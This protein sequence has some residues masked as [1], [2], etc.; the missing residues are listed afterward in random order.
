VNVIVKIADRE[1]IPVRAI[2][3]LTNWRFMEPFDIAH[4]LGGT[5]G[6]NVS[7]FGELKSY[8]VESDAVQS[9]NEDRWVQFSLV[10]LRALSRR[11][12]ATQPYDDEGTIEWM[13]RSLSILPP[14][15]FVWRSEYEALHRENWRSQYQFL[16]FAL[17][18]WDY[19]GE[20]N[21]ATDAQ[22]EHQLDR[23]LTRESLVSD[24]PLRRD[25][26]E[27]LAVLKRWREPD[28][29][30]F[31]LPDLAA[32][33]MEGF[34]SQGA[35]L[36][37]TGVGQLHDS[38]AGLF[39]LIAER[40]TLMKGMI[41]QAAS[42]E[43]Q[44]AQVAAAQVEQQLE[45]RKTMLRRREETLE[46]ASAT[47][48]EKNVT[49][50]EIAVSNATVER[51]AAMQRMQAM[52]GDFPERVDTDA[53]VMNGSS[54]SNGRVLGA[55]TTPQAAPVTGDT[56]A[57]VPT[58]EAAAA[59][60]DAP[61]AD[62]PASDPP[63]WKMRIQTEAAAHMKRLRASGA[64]PTVHSTVDHMAKWCRENDV[65]TDGSI[66]PSANYLRTHVLGGKHWTPPR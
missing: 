9:I 47:G 57:P 50:A 1:A 54:N 27:S 43:Y 23:E 52:R 53:P 31:L 40:R 7:I 15:A 61:V 55:D 63:Q 58:I 33:V 64:S 13:K 12:R 24:D 46:N 48:I 35:S 22:L 29:S 34:E 17:K 20:N 19:E 37:A 39:R 5:G 41:E 66:F 32:V 10:E 21:Q 44:Q 3:S 25:L 60:P 2:P 42:D 8:R 62:L 65:K 11:I 16:Y 26:R 51:D 56:V 6:S 4:V 49:D 45:G 38:Q 18:N 30:P 28:Y 14:G 36:H 59:P